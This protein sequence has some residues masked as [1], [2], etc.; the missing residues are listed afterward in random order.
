MTVAT[1]DADLAPDRFRL[2]TAVFPF[3]TGIKDV[4]LATGE[5]GG[6]IVA[7]TWLP[8]VWVLHSDEPGY[9]GRLRGAG[10]IVVVDVALFQQMTIPNCGGV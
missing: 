6:S 1:R 4:Y 2:V 8:N 3:D 7:D 10:A 5:A 9:A